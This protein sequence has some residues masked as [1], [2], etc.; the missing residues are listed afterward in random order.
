MF[1][2]H[3]PKSDVYDSSLSRPSIRSVFSIEKSNTSESTSS[4]DDSNLSTSDPIDSIE[5]LNASLFLTQETHEIKEENDMK[6][7]PHDEPES[8][9]LIE[10]EQTSELNDMV[11]LKENDL[12]SMEDIARESSLSLLPSSSPT[13]VPPTSVPTIRSEGAK[14]V[15]SA[16]ARRRRRRL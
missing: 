14:A 13:S 5:S 6:C 15:Q 1:K 10:K 8:T 16:K 12:D 2:I 4:L 9:Q 7:D 3:V 11:P